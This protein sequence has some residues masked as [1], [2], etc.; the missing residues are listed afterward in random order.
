MIRQLQA[1][2]EDS[3]RKN[4]EAKQENAGVRT[5]LTT[6][7]APKSIQVD[8]GIQVPDFVHVGN[9][10]EDNATP[11]VP[12]KD[13]ARLA[14]DYNTSCENRRVYQNSVVK[15]SAEARRYKSAA[16]NWKKYATRYEKYSQMGSTLAVPPV[17]PV[18]PDTDY[19]P[20]S[21][22][23]TAELESR[24]QKSMIE[25]GAR[26]P[27]HIVADLVAHQGLGGGSVWLEHA[28]PSL[29]E[30]GLVPDRRHFE[31][32][33]ASHAARSVIPSSSQTTES[34]VGTQLCSDDGPRI[35]SSPPVIISEKILKRKRGEVTPISLSISENGEG[36][37]AKPFQIKSEPQS[38]PQAPTTT[39]KLK[40]VET[41][42]L[43]EVDDRIDTPRKRR[44][45]H[46]RQ[47]Q[48]D[49]F[50]ASS[51]SLLSHQR[52]NSLPPT[53]KDDTTNRPTRRL[54]DETEHVRRNANEEKMPSSD[55]RAISEPMAAGIANIGTLARSKATNVLQ[56]ISSNL[57]ALPRTS[58]INE[59]L[60]RQDENRGANA[61]HTV[62]EDGNHSSTTEKPPSRQ[63]S[64]SA[65][66][67]D[68]LLDEPAPTRK[69]LTSPAGKHSIRQRLRIP[70]EIPLQSPKNFFQRNELEIELDRNPPRL[71]PL[72]VP[73]VAKLVKP[74]TP[75]SVFKTPVDS[76]R[77]GRNVPASEDTPSRGR[78]DPP[79]K[80]K[81]ALARRPLRNKAVDA[82]NID[83][84]KLNPK[85]KGG[86]DMAYADPVRGKEARRHMD[87]CTDPNCAKCGDQLQALAGELDIVVGSHLFASTQDEDLTNDERLIKFYLGDT[88]DRDKVKDMR[89]EL[90]TKMILQAKTR[91]MADRVGRHR[92]KPMGRAKSP[93]G[94]WDYDMPTT[95]Q[96]EA[97]R[98]EADARQKELIAERHREAMR[99]GGRWIFRDE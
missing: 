71:K 33:E 74:T 61:L 88:F 11:P 2:V 55:D 84:F 95:Q 54:D 15:L 40:R 69:Q 43:D 92:I 25:R 22:L 12:Y 96:L 38:S 78:P 7:E 47:K 4:D 60:R 63:T 17:R 21:R 42:D 36:T 3:Q 46:E 65:D 31:S 5:D 76:T 91:L 86:F 35:P 20:S 58:R 49:S 64:F 53:T 99:P 18:T 9:E 72:P 75:A 59:K 14:R 77:R 50:K 24:P 93:P 29:P 34:E 83:D 10:D 6:K 41:L 39:Q 28:N 97:Q 89:P 81:G 98:E 48:V 26:S 80:A 19:T 56:P 73:N 67:L 16:A 87:G 45:R 79:S 23:S 32:G 1:K 82:L 27:L 30:A 8:C 94:F 44:W 51:L 62:A 13:Y 66:L 90:R 57:K 37:P 70:S 68:H 85:A 52:S